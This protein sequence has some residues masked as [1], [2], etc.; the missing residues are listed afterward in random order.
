MDILTLFKTFTE[1]FPLISIIIYSFII[2]LFLTW[3]YK[4][5][6]DQKRMKEIRE[7]SAELRKESMKNKGDTK[8]VLEIQNEMM[9]L[10]MEQMKASFKS[11]IFTFIPIMFVFYFLKNVYMGL[12]L[13]NGGNIIYWKVDLPLF[14][15]GAGWF[16]CYIIFGVIFNSLLRKWMKV[17]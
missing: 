13:P 11:M 9:K 17:H 15:D 12:N 2:T 10:S 8:K 16:L 7:R 3:V 6:T 1:K 14:H 4:K 5:T